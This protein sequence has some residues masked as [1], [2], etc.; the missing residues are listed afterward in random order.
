[1]AVR[2]NCPIYTYEFILE[3]AGVVLE[4]Q[5]DERRP[6]P[7]A[8]PSRREKEPQG[9]EKEK[10]VGLTALSI[11]DLNKKLEDVLSKEDYKLA[12]QIR[13]EI[14]RRKKR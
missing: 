4:E 10:E 8:P 12:A 7:A 5:E 3:A 6:Q 1:M 9:K 11:D 14:N 2:F 13:D